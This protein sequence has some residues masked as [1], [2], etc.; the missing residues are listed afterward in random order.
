MGQKLVLQLLN[1]DDNMVL[2]YTMKDPLWGL[3]IA[4]EGW[5]PSDQAEQKAFCQLAGQPGEE[6]FELETGEEDEQEYDEAMNKVG[7]LGWYEH[8]TSG[9]KVALAK[10]I[11]I[12]R[13]VPIT[14]ICRE[15]SAL[16]FLGNKD[17]LLSLWRGQ[18]GRLKSLCA[19]TVII[20]LESCRHVGVAHTSGVLW[21]NGYR[22]ARKDRLGQHEGTS[23]YMRLP[24]GTCL[25]MNNELGRGGGSGLVGKPH[26]HQHGMP[27]TA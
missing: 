12:N 18:T 20:S 17:D 3:R 21:V 26:G 15:G 16:T 14:E 7:V 13:E 25:Q 8:N 10:H 4:C 11:H 19:A 9:Q 27:Q 24:Q 2:F 1:I 22:L 6:T 23:F 5:D